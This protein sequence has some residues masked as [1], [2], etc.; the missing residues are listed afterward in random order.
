MRRARKRVDIQLCTPGPHPVPAAGSVIANQVERLVTSRGIKYLP[1]T[2]LV[3]VERDR[4]AFEDGSTLKYDLFVA[5]P[6]HRPPRVVV[7]AGLTGDSGWVPVNPQNLATRFDD[8][9][10]IGDVTSIET[11]HGHAP[12]LPKAGL[13]AQ[14]PAGRVA[15]HI[16]VS[17]TGK[18]EMRQWD[19]MGS[20][21]LKGCRTWSY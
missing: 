14:G 7:E 9:Y 17:L 12:F 15:N 13:F 19:V 1:K 21:H 11:P 20:C 6:P 18:G 4:V 5:I 10:A 3:K 16:A 8:V 2:K